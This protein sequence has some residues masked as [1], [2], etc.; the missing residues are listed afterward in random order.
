MTCEHCGEAL[1]CFEGEW[2][3]PGCTRY[4]VEERARQAD[5]EA[6][7]LW[8]ILV[9]LAPGRPSPGR[10][11]AALLTS[12]ARNCHGPG[13]ALTSPGPCR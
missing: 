11:R 8:L 6:A 7:S 3:C 2:Y 12:P 4:E 9:P 1:A 13:E 5:R 10:R